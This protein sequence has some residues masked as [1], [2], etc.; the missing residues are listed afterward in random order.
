MATPA[1]L[2]RKQI[3]K[4]TS[5]GQITIPVDI[6]QTLGVK[7]GDKLVFKRGPGGEMLIQNADESPLDQIRWAPTGIPELDNG[8]VDDIVHWFR[9]ARGYD[10]I[11]D[12]ILGAK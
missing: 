8:S 6:R 5:K 11:D 2:T 9:E 10:E 1:P 12:Q 4:V 7:P 3:A